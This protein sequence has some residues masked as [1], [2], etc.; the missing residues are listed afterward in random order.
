MC[1]NMRHLR[2]HTYIIR[3]FEGYIIMEIFPLLNMALF[4]M[5]FSFLFSNAQLDVFPRCVR[6]LKMEKNVYGSDD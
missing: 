4:L 2:T 1:A 6:L 5:A 3:T